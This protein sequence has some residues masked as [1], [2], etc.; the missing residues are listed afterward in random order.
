MFY[1]TPTFTVVLAL[2]TYRLSPTQSF[3]LA[4]FWHRCW[5]LLFDVLN[6]C[7]TAASHNTLDPSPWGIISTHHLSSPL[8]RFTCE[9]WPTHWDSLQSGVKEERKE[10]STQVLSLCKFCKACRRGWVVLG[11]SGLTSSQFKPLAHF[12]EEFGDRCLNW[13][14]FLVSAPCSFFFLPAVFFF[15]ILILLPSP[16]LLISDVSTFQ[17]FKHYKKKRVRKRGSYL[18]QKCSFPASFT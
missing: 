12:F 5:H 8:L 11:D 18:K 17:H 13:Q 1:Q 14:P 15:Y 4:V 6:F 2:H 9:G 10:S 3:H 7:M 16:L